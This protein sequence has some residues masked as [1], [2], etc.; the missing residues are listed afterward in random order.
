MSAECC[1]YPDCGTLVPPTDGTVNT[2]EGT[3]YQAK[4]YYACN[5]GYTRTGSASVECQ[6]DGTWSGSAPTCTIVCK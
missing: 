4:A 6:A 5:T 1:P 3:K 2:D